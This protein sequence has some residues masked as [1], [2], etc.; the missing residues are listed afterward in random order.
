MENPPPAPVA[1]RRRFVDKLVARLLPAAD[2]SASRLRRRKAFVSALTGQ[3]SRLM[4][5]FCLVMNVLLPALTHNR[6]IS[7]IF[8]GPSLDFSHSSP[9]TW[10]RNVH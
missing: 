3:L 10:E 7:A 8:P 1:P 2:A 4:S 6:Q 9:T 5:V